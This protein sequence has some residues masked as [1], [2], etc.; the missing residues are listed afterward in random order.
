MHQEKDTIVALSTPYG[1]SG[2]GVIRLSGDACEG[3][4]RQVFKK[5]NVE[6]RKAYLGHYQSVDGTQLDQTLFIYFPKGASYTGEAM[7]EISCHGNPLILQLVIRDLIVRGCRH[8]EPGEF[9][10]RAFLNGILDL[11]QAEAVADLIHAKSTQ[12][13]SIAQKQLQ[14]ALSEK[15]H[16]FVRRLTESLAEVDAYLDFPEEDLPASNLKTLKHLLE[17]LSQDLQHLID[18]HAHCPS[19]TNGISTVI[20][21]PPNAGKSTLLNTLLGQERALV[22]DIPGTTRDFISEFV[23]IGKY[24]LRLID[25]A[26]LHESYDELERQGIEKTLQQIERA[27]LI[28]LVL[29]RSVELPA[30]PIALKDRFSEK[31]TVLLFNKTDLT[32]YL[33]NTSNFLPKIERLELSL[34]VS[35]D[36]V[37]KLKQFLINFLDRR[38]D[39]FS[40]APFM[41][42]ER[43][44]EGFK[45]AK[46]CL[47]RSIGLMQTNGFEDCLASEIRQAL[48]ALEQ[49]VGKMDYE[50]VLDQIFSRFCIGK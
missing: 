30:L 31:N 7:L 13:L 50:R 45:K 2:I 17:A 15:V 37:A 9:T 46:D 41:V 33:Q 34:K 38:F 8:A 39:G 21:G 3:L 43:H 4:A 10:R 18:A 11:C 36:H 25:T 6:P 12:A 14:G 1:E 26:G 47:Q 44:A 16:A 27:D 23:Q 5:T 22:S 48:C 49:V 32:P 24:G 35:L 40:M 28:L 29:D 42:H 19:L 20:I